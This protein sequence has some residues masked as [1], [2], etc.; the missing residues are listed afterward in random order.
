V[1][2]DESVA[3]DAVRTI[4]RES[5]GALLKQL[6]VLSVYTGKQIENG[7]KSIALGLQLQ[8]TSRTL[9]DNEADA[10]V[11]QVKDQLGRKLNATFRDN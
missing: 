11:A 9:T 6:S 2:V 8:D 3:A 5:A 4:V 1:I 10:V 7:K